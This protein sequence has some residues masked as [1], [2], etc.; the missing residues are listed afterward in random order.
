MPLPTADTPWPPANL[1]RVRDKMTVWDAWYSGDPDALASVYGGQWGDDPS[2]T[3]FFASERGGWRAAVGRRISRWF[4]G[5][6]TPSG[7]RR[8][9]L[10]VP[11]ASD[12]ATTSAALLFSEPPTV[13]GA[14]DATTDRLTTLIDDGLHGAL[15]EG[16]ELAAAL[17]GVY[18]RVL[19]DRDRYDAPWLEPHPASH[20]VPEWQWGRLAAVTFWRPLEVEGDRVVRHLE[21]HEPGFVLHGL[22]QG[23]RDS[24]GIRIPLTDHPATAPIAQ[25]L[26][27]RGDAIETGVRQL[28]AVYV[29][30]MRPNRLWRGTPAAAYLGRPDIAGAEPLLDALDEVYSSW[31]RDIHLGKA[32]IIVPGTYLES[33]GP[34]KGGYFDADRQIY[35]ELN[36]LQRPGD[37]A[38]I[39]PVQFGIRVA[40]H[41]DTA[42]D[43]VEQILRT[44]GYSAQTFGEQGQAAVTATEVVARERQSFTT[45]NRKIVYWRPAL[46]EALET[47]LAIDKA[48]YGTLVT[49]ARPDVAFGDS[50]SEDPK[51]L[52][53]TAELL[54]RADAASTETLVRLTNP[55]F[56]EKQVQAEAERILQESG[57]AALSDPTLTG[58]EG[59]PPDAGVPSDGGGSGP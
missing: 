7:E 59:G 41:R 36:M 25:A 45:R 1:D 30:N 54:R 34:G 19:W 33:N 20:A 58:A 38:M 10:H 42:Q 56:D 8:S 15:L 37:S 21:R 4:W 44:A 31:M 16:A 35:S 9:K 22:Y 49:V 43:L 14:D 52:A 18:L 28:T 47:L 3:G 12:I 26:G 13:T 32:R 55:G 6:P 11:V 24:L 5:T 46:A 51:T 53:E 40:E 39:T 29:P 57:R 50:V 2:D 48:V 17:G 27:P 23:T